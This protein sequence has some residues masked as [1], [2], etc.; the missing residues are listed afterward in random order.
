MTVAVCSILTNDPFGRDLS[1]TI[2]GIKIKRLLICNFIWQPDCY[3][4][5]TRAVGTVFSAAATFARAKILQKKFIIPPVIHRLK[6]RI[7]SIAICILSG[8]PSSLFFPPR[9]NFHWPQGKWK[10]NKVEFNTYCPCQRSCSEAKLKISL[11]WP[12]LQRGLRLESKGHRQGRKYTCS[13]TSIRS[14]LHREL[15]IQS[16]CWIIKFNCNL[17]RDLS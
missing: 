5:F 14:T 17:K 10:L 8:S 1:G 3:L 9:N 2:L 6:R 16:W 13:P 4:I 12:N 7:L 11:G 15:G